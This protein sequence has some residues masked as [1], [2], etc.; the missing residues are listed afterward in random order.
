MEKCAKIAVQWF[1]IALIKG[2]N[3]L[4][5]VSFCDYND[6]ETCLTE[7][8]RYMHD[9]RR[10][11]MK[12]TRLTRLLCCL[13]ALLMTVCLFAACAEETPGKDDQ[14]S[15]N[16][17][18]KEDGTDD[19]DKDDGS[20]GDQALDYLLS[21]EKDDFGKETITILCRE[22][23]SYEIDMEQD[24]GALVEKAVFDRNARVEEYL[25]VEIVGHPVNGSWPLQTEYINI[26]SQA[27]AATDNS[28]QLAATH[29]SYNAR[30][31]LNDQYWDLREFEDQINL[32]APWW[33][34]SWVENATVNDKLFFIT[35]DVSLT[36]WEELYAVFFNRQMAKDREEEVG[37]LYQLVRDGEWTLEMLAMLSDI[38]VDD[39]NDER[40]AGD[41]YGL[42][43]NRHSMRTFVT[44]CDLPIAKRNDDGG[45]DL[46]FMDEDHAEK[47]ATV[48]A[49]L[50]EM[51]Y[52]NDGTWD[53]KLTDG[54]YTEMLQIFT[55]DDGALFMTGTL[56]N[57]TA[58]RHAEMEFGIL[59]FPKYDEDQE[60]YLAH[61]Y[62]GLSSFAIPACAL[63]PEMSAK[64]LDAMGAESKTTVI[65]AYY[66]VVLQGRVAQDAES[67]E[68][69]NIIRENLYFDFGFIYSDALKHDSAAGPF[70]FF[71][72]EL[73]KGR[74]SL[75]SGWTSVYEGYLEKLAEV[76]AKFNED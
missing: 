17:D 65:P 51:I 2:I 24:S 12:A 38:Y 8:G 18:N 59:P 14:P 32:D 44:C 63:E 1:K 45:F 76:M 62:D 6:S 57:A 61:S 48:Y 72:D 52:Q 29:S 15:N 55:A 21:V 37:D 5:F 68:M 47:V 41:T 10:I 26:L 74:E 50:Y 7:A 33:S 56:Q 71:G 66:D 58:L 19:D 30:V 34:A 75:T 23:K 35:G 42:L 64:V 53:S 22:D 69:L 49:T 25:N 9:K 67:K 20:D 40:D 31:T 46:I 54:D 73:R 3:P 43:I 70:A 28:F 16:D 13:L 36:M 39:G 11:V 60:N 27:V 4:D